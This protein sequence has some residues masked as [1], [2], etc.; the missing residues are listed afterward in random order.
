MQSLLHLWQD[1][2]PLAYVVTAGVA[3]VAFVKRE[4]LKTGMEW[5]KRSLLPSR[6]KIDI[7]FREICLDSKLASLDADFGGYTIDTF[8]FF[9]VWVV[10]KNETPTTVKIWRLAVEM[11][12]NTVQAECV[13][14]I[15]KWHHQTKVSETHQGLPVVPDVREKLIPFS[16]QPLQHGIPLEGWVCFLVRGV[17]ESSIQTATVYLTLVDSFGKSHRVKRSGSWPSESQAVNPD[18]PW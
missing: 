15:S 1:F 17:R 5:C 2:H 11:D 7:E 6:P 18:M 16:T 4:A 14:D 3:V 13:P 10:N 8:M 9:R 12:G